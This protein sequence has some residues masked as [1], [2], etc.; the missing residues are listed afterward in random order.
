MEASVL[1]METVRAL[2]HRVS[3]LRLSSMLFALS[4]RTTR[5]PTA[6]S[7]L[8]MVMA[9]LLASLHRPSTSTSTLF[10]SAAA[11]FRLLSSKL[12]ARL[13]F[14]LSVLSTQLTSVTAILSRLSR[15]AA[16]RLS[17][18]L[19]T[20]VL[21]FSFR[22]ART[23]ANFAMASATSALQLRR[24]SRLLLSRLSRISAIFFAPVRTTL[25]ASLT[26]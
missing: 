24:A 10:R 15:T 26:L 25:S 20:S 13:A 16:A 7:L 21:T 11:T 3:K 12:P 18:R 9:L 1:G 2:L 22:T 5:M 23:L 6:L 4:C 17:V 14:L 8:S 19:Q